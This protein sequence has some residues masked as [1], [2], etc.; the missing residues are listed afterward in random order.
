MTLKLSGCSYSSTCCENLDRVWIC[1][2]SIN[3]S[4]RLL[5]KDA[6]SMKLSRKL[7]LSINICRES[8]YVINV[9]FSYEKNNPARRAGE[10]NNLAPILAEKNFS[11]RTKIPSPPPPWIS[12]GPCLIQKCIFGLLLWQTRNGCNLTDKDYSWHRNYANMRGIFRG[13]GLN[14]L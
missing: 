3:L 9:A 1:R 12:N 14:N 2:E 10:K 4:L 11:A 5:Q 6:L 7:E 8:L 13:G